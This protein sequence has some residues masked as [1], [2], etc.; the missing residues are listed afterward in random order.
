M[1]NIPCKNGAPAHARGRRNLWS[2]YPLPT[3]HKGPGSRLSAG[4][5]LFPA[6]DA[7]ADSPIPATRSRPADAAAFPQARHVLLHMRRQQTCPGPEPA[8]SPTGRHLTEPAAHGPSC[9][10]KR[11]P[12]QGRR[13][14]Y[15][16][17]LFLPRQEQSTCACDR[18]PAPA[19]SGTEAGYF[20]RTSEST[21][22]WAWAS[23]TFP[24][25]RTSTCR[26]APRASTP[27][28]G[29]FPAWPCIS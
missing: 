6:T 7:P 14:F 21:M 27:R 25:S 8:L 4:Q 2:I 28:M 16:N 12:S 18:C 29:M 26:S 24:A 13:S 3:P 1:E 19:G 10:K 11:P 20:F 23:S 17:G 9:H 22:A 5:R 15:T